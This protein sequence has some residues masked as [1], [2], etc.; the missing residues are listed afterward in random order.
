MADG[1][2]CGVDGMLNIW[3]KTPSAPPVATGIKNRK[4]RIKC[5]GNAVVPQ[6]AYPIFRALR[7]ELERMESDG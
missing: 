7:E 4:Q 1:I 6:Q 2:P 5:L 3:D